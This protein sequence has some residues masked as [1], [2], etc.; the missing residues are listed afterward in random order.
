MIASRS[1]L[2]TSGGG[3]E[4]G[5]LLPHST[6][7][8]TAFSDMRLGTGWRGCSECLRQRYLQFHT[9]SRTSL[10]DGPSAEAREALEGFHS[11]YDFNKPTTHLEQLIDANQINLTRLTLSSLIPLS[12][13]KESIYTPSSPCGQRGGPPLKSPTIPSEHLSFFTP[14]V[15]RSNLGKDGSDM[16]FNPPGGIFTR[17]MWAGGEMSFEKDNQLC[18]GDSAWES[19]TV[20]KAE[21]K[22]IKSKMGGEMIVV[23]VKK[24][25]GNEKGR[26]LIDRRSWIYQPALKGEQK[27]STPSMAPTEEIDG[28][29][30]IS[31]S[32]R[33]QVDAPTLFRYSALTFNAHAIHLSLPWAQ[34]VEG[35][36]G[37]VVH[38]PLNL[39]LILR[40]WGQQ[41]GGW[42]IDDDGRFTTEHGKH[43]RRIQY[44]AKKPIYADETYFIGFSALSS[45]RQDDSSSKIMAVKADGQVAMEADI[46][47]W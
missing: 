19:T 7:T 35:H 34:Q 26:C 22:Q 10:Q 24:E 39:S 36:P 23:W 20:E 4:L 17:R 2:K 37:I 14:R 30:S 9:S 27:I 8:V 43:I 46:T 29:D 18:I 16:S 45:E 44:R 15:G 3:G 33:L 38:G 28:P 12:N 1:M 6:S 13:E 5:F 40:K 25:I 41:I 47:S 21:W 11:R 32:T 42:S 31:R